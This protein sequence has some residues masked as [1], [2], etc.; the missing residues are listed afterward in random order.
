MGTVGIGGQIWLQSG[1]I[2]GPALAQIF[3]TG[4]FAVGGVPVFDGNGN[5]LFA[6]GGS[7]PSNT[8]AGPD[9]YGAAANV[10]TSLLYSRGDHNHGLPPVPSLAQLSGVSIVGPTSGEVL[11]YNG[12]V[13]TNG[14]VVAAPLASTSATGVLLGTS[15]TGVLSYTPTT[16]VLV[17]VTVTLAAS[18]PTTVTLSLTY[19]DPFLGA[20]TV[21]LAS[22]T[23]IPAGVTSLSFFLVSATTATDVALTGSA[24]AAST[25][26]AYASYLSGGT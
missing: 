26:T 15:S 12:T 24:A 6:T 21:P 3:D 4:G 25:V 9:A 18:S 7:I 22:G 17:G 1:N 8:V 10:G 20:Q 14:S 5:P 13:W 23:S 2:S 11:Q 19:T 16:G